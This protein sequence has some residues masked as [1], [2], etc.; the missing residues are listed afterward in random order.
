MF[1]I[2][3]A[4]TTCAFHMHLLLFFPQKVKGY[5]RKINPEVGEVMMTSFDA[6]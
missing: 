3:Y 1:S 2:Y 5:V 6:E 4:H